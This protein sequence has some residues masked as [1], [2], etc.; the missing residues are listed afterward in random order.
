MDTCG[1]D[2]QPGLVGCGCDAMD[3]EL[4]E[5]GDVEGLFGVFDAYIKGNEW[6]GVLINP[7]F[8]L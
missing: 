7:A 8:K 3:E 5:T 1:R 2:D 6:I 4:G